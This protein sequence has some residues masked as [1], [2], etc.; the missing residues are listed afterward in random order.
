MGYSQGGG[1]AGWAG[2]LQGSYAPELNVRG[3]VAGGVP[4]DL[5]AVADFLDGGPFVIFELLAGI[6]LDAAYAELDLA[7]YLNDRGQDLMANKDAACL[8]NV[9]EF[10]M[11]L[12]TLVD[13]VFRRLDD[14]TTTNPLGTAAWQARLAENKLGADRP[15]A[16]VFM[17]HGIVDEIIP[18]RQA[19]QLRRTWCNQGAN[20]RWS[21]WPGEHALTMVEAYG[22]AVNWLDDRFDGH[23]AWSNCW[24]P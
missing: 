13:T 15:Q 23:R 10:D 19:A 18:L 5:A 7:S 14:Y 22:A 20:V 16:P 9:D 6:G 1:A 21:L 2:Q 24:L 4:G 8:V 3:V 17:Y 12:T 11:L